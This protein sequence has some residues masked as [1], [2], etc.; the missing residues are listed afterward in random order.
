M[1]IRAALEFASSELA[2]VSKIE[3][4]DPVGCVQASQP[5]NMF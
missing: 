5:L 1:N 2:Q 3:K 4:L